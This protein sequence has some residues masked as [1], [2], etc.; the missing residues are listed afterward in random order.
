MSDPMCRVCLFA[1]SR[2]RDVNKKPNE[3]I[4]EEHWSI[5]EEIFVYDQIYVE[6]ERISAH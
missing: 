6:L 4:F 3:R 2:L 5:N 1:L